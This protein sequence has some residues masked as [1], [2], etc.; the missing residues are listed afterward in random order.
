M[1]SDHSIRAALAL[2][3]Q[4]L[5]SLSEI[6]PHAEIEVDLRYLLSDLL[7]KSPAYLMAFDDASLT[8]EQWQQWD[9]WLARRQQG[10]P[11]AYITGF[12]DFWSL[13]LQVS[14]DTLIPRADTERLVEVALSLPVPVS[15]K[16]IDLGTGT[17]AIAL[18]LADERPQW[19]VTGV[20]RIPQAVELAR[21]N[22]QRLHLPVAFSQ[23]S[24]LEGITDSVDLI[25]SNP[26]YID[27]ADAHLDQGDVRFEPHSALVAAESGLADIRTIIQQAVKC[28]APSGWLLFEHGWKQA[29]AVRD[30][31][32]AAAFGEIK[33][34]QD[35]GGNDRVTGGCWRG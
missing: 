18:A 1:V 29:E 34:W 32:G 3:R 9:A 4:Q 30:M 25:V 12:R 6:D 21:R 19:L 28:L 22:A 23:G 16:V 26:P 14:P 35:L 24:W 31:L 10:E 5:A 2:G 17:G 27:A 15:A 11:V 13:R 33:T 20:D 8:P 7:N